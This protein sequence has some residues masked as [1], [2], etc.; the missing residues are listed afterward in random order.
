MLSLFVLGNSYCGS[1]L[2]T[3]IQ[4]LS[5]LFQDLPKGT[6]EAALH[7]VSPHPSRA[8]GLSLYYQPTRVTSY[9][10]SSLSAH[11]GLRQVRT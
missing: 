2:I 5:V 1:V 3:I 4:V 8:G 10:L 9:I 11:R 7:P 6:L